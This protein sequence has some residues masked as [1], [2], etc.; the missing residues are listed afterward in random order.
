M[1]NVP[2]EPGGGRPSG[3]D[4]EGRPGLDVATVRWPGAALR[5]Y[6][7]A[8]CA[9]PAAMQARY[10]CPQSQS[11]QV[12]SWFDVNEKSWPWPQ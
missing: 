6:F 2:L 8:C 9:L 11:K 10:G 5:V 1:P 3:L 12:W 7:A 4:P